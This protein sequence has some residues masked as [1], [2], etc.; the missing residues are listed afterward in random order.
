MRRRRLPSWA[1]AALAGLAPALPALCDEPLG[2]HADP[3]SLVLGAGARAT[4]TIVAPCE[5]PP[6][7]TT[8]LGRVGGLRALGGGRFELDYLPP[9]TAFPQV[10]IVAAAACDGWG[11]T[12]ISLTGH[13]IAIARAAPHA[14]IRVTIGGASF[15][16]VRADAAGEA[17]VPVVVPAGVDRAYHRD[18]PL[19]LK[20]PATLH[21]HVALGRD[22][23]PADAQQEVPLRVFA[24]TSSGAPRAGAAVL[25]EVTSGEVVALTEVAP[26]ELGATWR[27]P[28]GAAEPAT[29]TAR[30]ADEG[31]LA[32][33]AS[34]SRPA[35]AAARVAIEADRVR[36]VAG[37]D[38]P[39]ALRAAV[40][41]MAGNPVGDPPRFEAA[42]GALS[43]PRATG[44]GAWEARLELPAAVK[45]A[46]RT[47][48]VVRAAGGIEGRVAIDIAPPPVPP[49]LRVRRLSAA[50]K[51]GVS[52]SPGGLA[53]AY[54]GA[55]GAWRPALLGDRLS[56]ALEIGGFVRDRTDDVTV[57][58]Q[59]LAVHGR[60]RYVPA[61]AS[62]RLHHA[63]RAR[64]AAWAGVGA[65]LAHV[66]SDVSVGT[67][68]VTSES[69]VVPVLHASGAWGLRVG[70]ATPFAEARLAWHG[71]PGFE[72][73]RGS[74]TTL[75]FLL[76]CRYDAY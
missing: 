71:D 7:V 36:A 66:A 38:P 14:A 23:A 42:L 37:V 16:P 9:P 62:L 11:W 47:E 20:V 49:W 19:D 34:L 57:G 64:Q 72:A 35:G 63:L 52:A 29:A 58:A 17:K 12:A 40:T 31:G 21:V 50:P 18:K 60:A 2:V 13:G 61:L 26:G 70:R 48:V 25:L 39:I 56:L 24:V 76:G 69:G 6:R 59:S 1:A 41:D 15:G 44:P 65:G 75:T 27:L 73:L 30:L 8:S 74:L 32:S 33:A 5:A 4:V 3:P 45:R 53:A 51:L 22:A 55:E 67:G 46:V 43:A 28:P 68:P 10:A 54:L